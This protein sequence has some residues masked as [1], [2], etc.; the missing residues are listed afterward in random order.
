MHSVLGKVVTLAIT[1]EMVFF[2]DLI[3]LLIAN[4]LPGNLSLHFFV[5]KYDSF[6]CEHIYNQYRSLV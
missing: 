6:A 5:S 2:E 4:V 1:S 3:M